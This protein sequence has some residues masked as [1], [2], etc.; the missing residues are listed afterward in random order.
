METVTLR[1]IQQPSGV[2]KLLES[3]VMNDLPEGTRQL[4]DRGELSALLQRIVTQANKKDRAWSAWSDD[5]RIWLFT[6]EMSLPLSRERGLPVL[7]VNC[8]GED[9]ELIKSGSWVRNPE[10][11]W[12]RC[13]D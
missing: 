7:Q 2:E 1:V 12:Q 6:A 4:R 5:H 8:H 13:A 10:G 11:K 3:F 9:G